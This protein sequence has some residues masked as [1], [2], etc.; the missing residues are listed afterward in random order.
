MKKYLFI[1][2]L[3][4]CLAPAHAQNITQMEYWVD[5]DS[6]FGAGKP[7]TGFTAANNVQ[8]FAFALPSMVSSGIHTVGLRSKDANNIWSHSNIFQALVFTPTPITTV[9]SIEYFIDTD[10]GSGSGM[11]ITGFT[12]QQ[13]IQSLAFSIPITGL[14]NGIHT[15]GV[16][17]KG[18][19]GKWSH[20]NFFP[21]L[22]NDTTTSVIT[23]IEYYWD[24]DSGFYY[25]LP[26]TPS[27]IVSD[28]SN[29]LLNAYAPPGLSQGVHTL[30]LRSR[31]SRGRWSHVNYNPNVTV[32]GYVGL[33]ALNNEANIQIFPNPFTDYIAVES[34][35]N[36]RM[37]VMLYDAEGRMVIDK[38]FSGSGNVET[39]N[40]STGVYTLMVWNGKDQ[41]YKT[42]LIK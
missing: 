2:W 16:R 31:D 40:L 20:T 35:D 4:W 22:I 28:L 15:A 3:L 8:G 14:S 23:S 30:F 6:G 21:F 39:S 34:K 5:V 25:Y 1:A 33:N 29:E 38:L 42:T 26:Y 10:N 27:Q 11:H 7:I 9:D 19:D 36:S 12:A 37:H 41:I 32:S 17:A 24:V 13:N 18:S